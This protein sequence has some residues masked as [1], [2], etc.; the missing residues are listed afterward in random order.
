MACTDDTHNHQDHGFGS[1]P[2]AVSEEE[3][4]QEQRH[5]NDVTRGFCDYKMFSLAEIAR[6][7]RHFSYLSTRHKALV[8][9]FDK[10]IQGLKVASLMN[11]RFYLNVVRSHIPEDL[12][13]AAAQGNS[14]SLKK[15][16]SYLRAPPNA[17]CP[18]SHFQT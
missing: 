13:E 5:F 3:Q 12:F 10:K 8:P 15:N 2:H 4:E 16:N 18:S 17:N 9:D 1:I 6:R 11:S 7:E 14:L